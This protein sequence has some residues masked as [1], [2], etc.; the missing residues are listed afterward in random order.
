MESDS[1][2]LTWTTYGT[3]LPGDERGFVGSVAESVLGNPPTGVGGSKATSPNV[4]PTV[5]AKAIRVA[6]TS[7]VNDEAPP[8]KTIRA[9][10]ASGL[11]DETPPAKTIRPADASGRVTHNL[12]GTPYDRAMPGLRHHALQQM[13]GEPVW[14]DL[15]QAC[16]FLEEARRVAKFRSWPLHAVAVMANHAHL[17]VTAPKGVPGERLLQEFK[18]YGSRELNRRFGKRESGTWWTK[19]GST[20]VLSHEKALRSA[21]EYAR[22]QHRPLALW[23]SE[24]FEPTGP[25][26]RE[27]A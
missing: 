24:K 21:V 15:P 2:L 13:R 16:L 6:D 3:W 19:S 1:W 4:V 12:P 11:N 5:Q 20:R 8:A 22:N 27:E 18:S 9:A 14:L 17:V 23:I 7:G 10:D 25:N 26:E